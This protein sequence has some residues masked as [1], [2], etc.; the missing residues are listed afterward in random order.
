[1]DKRITWTN[2]WLR[3]IRPSIAW[4]SPCPVPSRQQN[5]LCG[6]W[7]KEENTNQ[8]T[9]KLTKHGCGLWAENINEPTNW[10]NMNLCVLGPEAGTGGVR[11]WFGHVQFAIACDCR[12][13]KIIH[14]WH[15]W[16]SISLFT[17]F[18]SLSRTIVVLP[19]ARVQRTGSLLAAGLEWCPGSLS[20]AVLDLLAFS[21]LVLVWSGGWASNA[22]ARFLPG[23]R[24]LAMVSNIF[25]QC[26][27][28]CSHASFLAFSPVK[29]DSFLVPI[30]NILESVAGC[31]SRQ[32]FWSEASALA[33]TFDTVFWAD[34]SRS[35]ACCWLA[36]SISLSCIWLSSM[37]SIGVC[38][39]PQQPEPQR[40]YP[41]ETP[42]PPLKRL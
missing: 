22:L 34:E 12:C 13:F 11:G 31:M 21:S 3:Q 7:H 10:W 14:S 23:H 35:W 41:Q 36:S 37:P 33:V 6:T 26:N 42:P 27:H 40:P 5:R 29:W 25:F 30:S 20:S 28:S 17:S 24:T 15:C 8:R 1:M 38:G 19:K 18:L 4:V 2:S 9:T 16:P 39:G 32:V